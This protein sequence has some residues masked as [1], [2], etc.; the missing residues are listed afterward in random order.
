MRFSRKLRQRLV[1]EYSARHGGRFDPAGFV[2]EAASPQHEAHSWF[3]W[4]D[5]KAADEYRL[6]QARTFVND[7]RVKFTVETVSRGGSV[8][9]SEEE[10]PAFISPLDA[11]RIGGYIAVDPSDPVAMARLCA[12]ASAALDAWLR[13]YRGALAWSGGHPAVLEKQA[14]LLTANVKEPAEAA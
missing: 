7:L 4:D 5:A 12:E 14:A 8:R 2:S 13:R 1:D 11:R 6:W 9:V 10:C 3:V